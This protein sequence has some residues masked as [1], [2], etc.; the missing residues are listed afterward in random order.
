MD[1]KSANSGYVERNNGAYS[2]KMERM[3]AQDSELGFGGLDFHPPTGYRLSA[4]K[5]DD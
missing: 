2:E 5:M 4:I 3:R 1:G